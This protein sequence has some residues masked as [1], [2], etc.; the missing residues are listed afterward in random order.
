MKL[1]YIEELRLLSIIPMESHIRGWSAAGNRFAGKPLSTVVL[2]K[3]CRTYWFLDDEVLREASGNILKMIDETGFIEKYAEELREKASVLRGWEGRI[4]SLEAKNLRELESLMH[5]YAKAHA[6]MLAVGGLSGILDYVNDDQENEYARIL[7]KNLEK[8]VGSEKAVRC[9]AELTMPSEQTQITKERIA[10]LEL[11]SGAADAEKRAFLESG[12]AAAESLK[13][14]VAEHQRRFCWLSFFIEGPVKWDMKYYEDLLRADLAGGGAAGEL[15]KLKGQRKTAEGRKDELR[16]EL[17]FGDEELRRFWIAGEMA[18]LKAYR[19]EEL[20]LSWYVLDS[21]LGEIAKRLGISVKELRLLSYEEIADCLGGAPVPVE[22][23][24]ARSGDRA[25]CVIDGVFSIATGG[26]ERGFDALIAEISEAAAELR[27]T[28]ASAGFARGI[29]RIVNL[30]EDLGKMNEGDILVSMSTNPEMV[31]A[32]RKAAAIVTDQGGLTCHAAIVSRE[33]GVPCVVG[34]R[35]ATR[36]L[37]DGDLV[38]V[39][40]TRGIVKKLND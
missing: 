3:N 33:L 34:T 24:K 18:Y 38:E 19:I 39:D 9:L 23:I 12:F 14:R 16:E 7:R 22:K 2:I 13:G 37:K 6:D 5:D 40:A 8:R 35:N 30:K 17:S 15:E 11:V 20:T 25:L 4:K 1:K 28:C 32:M 10:W 21:L 26:D 27:G 36:I 31:L 29:V